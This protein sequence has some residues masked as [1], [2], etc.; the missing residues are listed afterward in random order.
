MRVSVV[1]RRVMG[2][3]RVVSGDISGVIIVSGRGVTTTS[4]L[5]SGV[6]VD[7]SLLGVFV[8]GKVATEVLVASGFNILLSVQEEREN[9][10]NTKTAIITNIVFFILISL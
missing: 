7:V 4:G 9:A 1:G 3:V 8:A 10:E 6:G 2:V 5:T